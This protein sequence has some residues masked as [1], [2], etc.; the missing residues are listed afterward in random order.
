MATHAGKYE[1]K[2]I[3]HQRLGRFQMKKP[4]IVVLVVAG[5]LCLLS[6]TAAYAYPGI[7][8]GQ[9][10]YFQDGPGTTGGGEFNVYDSLTNKL[11][12]QSF[13]LETNEY[14]S[15]GTK[16]KVADISTEARN[17]GSGGPSP[18]PISFQTAYLYHHFYHQ[19][20]AEYDYSDNPSGQFATRAASANALQKAIWYFEGEVDWQN[21]A[22]NFYV[23]LANNSVGDSPGKWWGLGDVRVINLVY[24][25]ASGKEFCKQDQLTV[26]PVPEPATMLLVGCGLIGLAGMGRRKIKK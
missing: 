4:F 18:D 13:C 6:F 3:N 26:A 12:Y 1:V 5:F 19:N 23:K 20:L 15:Y 17:G 25:D 22:D 7:Y 2:K 10:I 9:E 21:Q 8:V 14:I 24:V 16:Y 11:L